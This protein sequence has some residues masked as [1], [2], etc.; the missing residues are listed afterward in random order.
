MCNFNAEVPK[1]SKIISV[2][3]SDSNRGTVV[4]SVG[5][6]SPSFIIDSSGMIVQVIYL[7][8]V[9]QRTVPAILKPQFL[10]LCNY[11]HLA[12]HPVE[13]HIYDTIK[14]RL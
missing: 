3:S 4:S 2:P 9:P 1:L 12:G 6:L 14:I 7:D 8:R 10:Q 13:R 11:F 5:E